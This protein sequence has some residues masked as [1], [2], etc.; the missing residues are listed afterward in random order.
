MQRPAITPYDV[1]MP[2]GTEHCLPVEQLPEG[3]ALAKTF[4]IN[5]WRFYGHMSHKTYPTIEALLDDACPGWQSYAEHVTPK[6]MTPREETAIIKASLRGLGINARVRHYL[7]AI[8]VELGRTPGDGEGRKIREE[9]ARA[10]GQPDRFMFGGLHVYNK[11]EG[12]IA[13]GWSRGDRKSMH[14]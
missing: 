13:A 10:L 1:R 7:G 2:D 5:L 9:V 8:V 11:F 4:V 14:Y 3:L 6:R 12:K